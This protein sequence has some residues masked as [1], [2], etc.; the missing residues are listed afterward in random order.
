VVAGKLDRQA[1]NL[2]VFARSPQ[3][4]WLSH[5]SYLNS[6]RDHINEAGRMLSELQSIRHGVAPWQQQAI[7]AVHPVAARLA[8]HIQAAIEHLNENKSLYFAPEYNSRLTEIADH[9]NQMKETVHSYLEYAETQSK[10]D[11]LKTALGLAGS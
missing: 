7:D 5:A 8:S 9:A 10:L 2:D 6:V 1:E 3:Y 4:S 11:R